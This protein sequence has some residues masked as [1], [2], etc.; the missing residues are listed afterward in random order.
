MRND[1]G[2]AQQTPPCAASAGRNKEQQDTNREFGAAR[3]EYPVDRRP[4]R[5]APAAS[6]KPSPG[7]ALPAMAGRQPRNARDRRSHDREGPSDDLDGRSQERR[8]VYGGRN[9]DPAE[10]SPPA[11]MTRDPA[12]YSRAFRAVP[13]RRA[14]RGSIFGQALSYRSAGDREFRI[15]PRPSAI[16]GRERSAHRV[17]SPCRIPRS[18]AQTR[19]ISGHEKFRKSRVS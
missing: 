17:L 19:F 3:S 2:R 6:N 4:E 14:S 12:D 13:A 9:G 11:F 8:D 5:K 18:G 15:I 10:T 1:A 7:Q 16:A